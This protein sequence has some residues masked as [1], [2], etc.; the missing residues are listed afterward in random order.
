MSDMSNHPGRPGGGQPNDPKWTRWH[1]VAVATRDEPRR[2]EE[3]GSPTLGLGSYVCNCCAEPNFAI[4]VVHPDGREFSIV[5]S[6][7]VMSGL[8][9]DASRR[10]ADLGINYIALEGMRSRE[11]VSDLA[12]MTDTEADFL[13][14]SGLREACRLILKGKQPPTTPR[15]YGEEDERRACDAIVSRYYRGG[16]PIQMTPGKPIE[17]VQIV[18]EA[19]GMRKAGG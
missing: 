12:A 17:L 1:G 2:P 18:A 8:M 13:D 5:F 15:L 7:D 19:L 11:L 9:K 6:P 4:A 3:E 14:G 10:L 16:E